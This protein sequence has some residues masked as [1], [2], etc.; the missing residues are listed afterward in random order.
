MFSSLWLEKIWEILTQHFEEISFYKY[1][2][3][4]L[5]FYRSHTLETEDASKLDEILYVKNKCENIHIV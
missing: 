4:N 2:V 1:I 3:P 5:K